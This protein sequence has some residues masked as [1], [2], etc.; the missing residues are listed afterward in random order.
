MI[1]GAR[2]RCP[3]VRRSPKGTIQAKQDPLSERCR[4]GVAR[5][6]TLSIPSSLSRMRNLPWTSR[7]PLDRAKK[8]LTFRAASARCMQVPIGLASRVATS[9]SCIPRAHPEVFRHEDRPIADRLMVERVEQEEKTNGGIILPVI[10]DSAKRET[11]RRVR[12]CYRQRQGTQRWESA[13][14]VR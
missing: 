10:P 14:A 3:T 7:A 1:S 9:E 6:R 5:T 4:L 13:A 8:K 2:I 11:R 12:H